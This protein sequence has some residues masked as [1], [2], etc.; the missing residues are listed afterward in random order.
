[1][2]K[3]L[4]QKISTAETILSSTNPAVH[5]QIIEFSSRYI[6]NE[7]NSMPPYRMAN[8]LKQ[9]YDEAKIIPNSDVQ[10]LLRILELAEINQLYTLFSLL[11]KKEKENLIEYMQ[12]QMFDCTSIHD[13]LQSFKVGEIPWDEAKSA[14]IA[15]IN[16]HDSSN[17]DRLKNFLPTVFLTLSTI[18]SPVVGEKIIDNIWPDDS[19]QKIQRLLQEQN[20]LE[21][22]RIKIEREL[23][24][25]V[26]SNYLKN[27]SGS[28]D[29]FVPDQIAEGNTLV[30]K[31]YTDNQMDMLETQL[32]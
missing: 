16:P 12:N 21:R 14:F 27:Q 29:A 15:I 30:Q 5:A 2:N 26:K 6:M 1:M 22:E 32:K 4:S 7:M 3:S 13:A 28:T 9:K 23:L 31:M 24:A 11:P 20:D 17:L 8:I 25:I 19:T 18:F 10:A